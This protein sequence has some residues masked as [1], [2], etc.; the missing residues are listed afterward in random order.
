MTGN[1]SV[2]GD[3]GVTGSISA[4]GTDLLSAVN[5]LMTVV[6]QLTG[7][8]ANLEAQVASLSAALA[9]LQGGA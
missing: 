4:R 5:Q 3:I 2:G 6:N 7:Q 8:V 1:V 9:G